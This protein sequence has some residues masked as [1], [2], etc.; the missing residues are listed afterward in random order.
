MNTRWL[1]YRLQAMGAA[2]IVFRLRRTL[3]LRWQAARLSPWP[4]SPRLAEPSALSFAA[5]PALGTVDDAAL[6]EAADAVL[7]GEFDVFELRGKAL[8]FPPPSRVDPSSGLEM[9]LEFG[10]RLDYRDVKRLGDVRYLWEP[11]R[12]RELVTLA[13]AWRCTAQPRYAFACAKWLRSWWEDSPCPLGPNWASSLEAALRLIAWSL[14]WPMLEGSP[15][16]EGDSG[17]SFRQRWLQSIHE[18]Q[19]FVMGHLSRHSSA[20]NH[21]FG[22]LAGVFVASWVWPCWAESAA[23]RDQSWQELQVQ[24]ELQIA[25]DGVNRE[26]AMGYQKEVL[27]MMLHCSLV[28][29]AHG[30]PLPKA[31][32]QRLN[33]ASEFIAA[34]TSRLGERPMIGDSDDACI[35]VLDPCPQADPWQAVVLATRALWP[36]VG[37]EQAAAAAAAANRQARWWLGLH[38]VPPLARS[39]WTDAAAQAL[40]PRLFAEGGYALLGESFGTT[41]EVKLL[42]DAGPLGYLGIA[43]HGHADALSLTLSVRGLSLLVDPGTYVYS[44]DAAWRRWMCS[45]AAHNTMCIDG[46]SQAQQHGP[47]LWLAHPRVTLIDAGFGA[48]RQ[49]WHAEHDGYC[50][51]RQPVT[52]RRSLMFVPEAGCFEI[53]DTAIGSGTHEYSLHWHL[54]PACQVERLG[55][56]WRIRREDVVIDLLLESGPGEWACIEGSLETPVPRP[57]PGWFSPSFGVLERSLTLRLQHTCQGSMEWRWRIRLN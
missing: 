52:H 50:R 32:V 47:F 29:R 31:W 13:Q 45:T 17:R 25:P 37:D 18:H 35:V 24:V 11:N 19:R 7:R 46:Q 40:Q 28:A 21:L 56:G 54:H 26:Q 49:R 48:D 8:G 9:P 5:L 23:W 38:D 34:V 53:D 33:A 22:E 12:Q 43:A 10:K 30:V 16:F 20:N 14:A 6:C 44:R 55:T 4:V 27:E 2:E 36:K 39:P 51:L 1:L 3:A 15:I 41:A 57:G 42:A